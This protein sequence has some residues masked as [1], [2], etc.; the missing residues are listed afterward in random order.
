MPIERR[1]RRPNS[2]H[3]PGQLE[4]A[5]AVWADAR[6]AQRYS[7]L[8]EWAR[9]TVARHEQ[10]DAQVAPPVKKQQLSVVS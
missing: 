3:E 1:S 10:P 5:R 2:S 7:R 9:W 4:A 8:L 6:K